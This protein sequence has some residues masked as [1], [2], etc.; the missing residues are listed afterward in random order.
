MA[1]TFLIV[2]KASVF[3]QL[4]KTAIEEHWRDQDAVA[5]HYDVS[6]N[7]LPRAIAYHELTMLI[8][9]ASIDDPFDGIQFYK[10]LCAPN[11][12]PCVFY[13]RHI[14]DELRQAAAGGCT[15][16]S[17][18]TAP[19]ELLAQLDA[20]IHPPQEPEPEEDAPQNSISFPDLD[21]ADQAEDVKPLIAEP[22]QATKLADVPISALQLPSEE[23]FTPEETAIP[24]AAE[25]AP[26]EPANNVAMH[27]PKLRVNGYVIEKKI[28]EGGMSSIYL[29]TREE[30]NKPAVLKTL[31]PEIA[32]A[33]RLRT[34]ERAALEFE[35]IS[36]IKH[37]NVVRLYEHGQ[38]N[39]LVYTTMEYFDT[40][41]LKQRMARGI[42]QQQA[43]TYMLQIADG[44]NAIHGCGII[45]RDLKP[46]NIMFRA[47]ETLAI[48][49]FGIAKDITRKLNLTPKGMRLGTPSYM[50]PEQGSTGYKLGATSDLYSLG[51][52]LY[53]MLTKHRPYI[54]RAKNVIYSHIHDP[55]PKL[56][57][58]FYEMQVLIDKLMAKFPHERFE[59][60]YDLILFIRK[61]YRFEQTLGLELV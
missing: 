48:L 9:N 39:D 14:D 29:C 58:E 50:S 57:I 22:R 49:D 42:T 33:D 32:S 44:L 36:R 11:L 54:G 30:D 8:I 7:G 10:N 45:H 5:I 51:V 31:L 61:T 56:P 12:P 26:E 4:L 35:V 34:L 28:A 53:E 46:A 3:S 19:K 52:M 2:D 17:T 18:S 38:I 41:D 13:A 23:H 6:S 43:L 55:I 40:G 59:S 20:I 24:P 16:I 37:P 60:A 25:D 1:Y 27:K 47:D 21:L 15:L